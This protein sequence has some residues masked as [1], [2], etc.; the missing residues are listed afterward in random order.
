[1][2]DGKGAVGELLATLRRN[3]GGEPVGVYAVCSVHPI[4]LEAAMAQARDDGVPLL[5]EST[6]N[7]VNQYGGYTGYKPAD[8]P[9]YVA[10]IAGRAGLDTD[11]IVL[12][13]D[14]LGPI[15]WTGESAEV[16]MDKACDLVASY[17]D[18][19]FVKLH[20]DTSVACADDSLPLP[21]AVVADRAARLCEVAERVA[22]DRTGLSRP[23]YVVGS[24]VPPAGGATDAAP[25]LEVTTA[26]C[27][28]RTVA[29]HRRAFGSRGLDDAWS[30]VIGVV[31]QPGVEFDHSSV[32]RYA[33]ERANGLSRALADLPG[34][35]FEAHSTD[36][37]PPDAY[38]A[39]LHDHFAILKVGPEL[40]FALREALFG[41]SAIEK[42]L[43]AGVRRCSELP[44]VCERVMLEEPGHWIRHHP[45]LQPQSRWRRLYSYSDRIRYYW[46][47][48]RIGRALERL[49]QNLSHVDIPMPL[50]SQFLPSQYQ[51][52]RDGTLSLEPRQLVVHR[53]M[54]VTS[55]YSAACRGIER[56]GCNANIARRTAA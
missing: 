43:L 15:C 7:Q 5:V 12:G 10:N 46:S 41:L 50:L 22:R 16:A 47:H 27:V 6:A 14:H 24:E 49:L 4:V 3:R 21:E 26:A 55:T 45:P 11:R 29:A 8:L 18:A 25:D 44:R 53:V 56:G 31:V 39:L 36:Y 1:M 34:L 30:R 9:A 35:V 32:R 38:R 54:E 13:G 19:G 23:V 28:R 37:Q 2:I 40:T 51:A 33:P 17:V 52:V 48:P 42:E 20:L